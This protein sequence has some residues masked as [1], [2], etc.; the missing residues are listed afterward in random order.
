MD[1][2]LVAVIGVG[3]VAAGGW[4]AY[5]AIGSA[6][7]RKQVRAAAETE[8]GASRVELELG[9][10]GSRSL[11]SR[12]R[13]VVR[14]DGEGIARIRLDRGVRRVA[15]ECLADEESYEVELD[16]GWPLARARWPWGRARVAMHRRSDGAAVGEAAQPRSWWRRM[17]LRGGVEFT[18]AGVSYELRPL[19]GRRRGAQLRADDE[20]VGSFVPEHGSTRCK[21]AVPATLDDE[22]QLFLVSVAAA[23]DFTIPDDVTGPGAAL[24]AEADAAPRGIAMGAAIGGV[25]GGGGGGGGGC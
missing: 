10:V 4:F 1:A 15:G 8:D 17:A 12:R 2:I 16:R 19:R 20:A 6:V 21:A 23:F 25:A 14:R 24:P 22:A 7:D 3:A 9:H 18:R 5:A 11:L 13:V